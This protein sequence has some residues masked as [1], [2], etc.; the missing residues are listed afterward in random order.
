MADSPRRPPALARFDVI[1]ATRVDLLLAVWNADDAI[2]DAPADTLHE[3]PDEN[4]SADHD[5]A[6]LAAADAWFTTLGRSPF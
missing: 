4:L 3:A 2:E 6:T 1:D 5:A